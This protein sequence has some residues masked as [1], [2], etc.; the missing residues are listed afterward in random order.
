MSAEVRDAKLQHRYA[1]SVAGGGR[2]L[3]DVFDDLE[4]SLE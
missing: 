1:Q 4:R 3:G 2:P